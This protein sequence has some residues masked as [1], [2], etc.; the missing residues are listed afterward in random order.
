MPSLNELTGGPTRRQ[1]LLALGAALGGVVLSGAVDAD[2]VGAQIPP[3]QGSGTASVPNGYA[4][5]RV[6]TTESLVPWPGNPGKI[7]PIADLTGVVLM[8]GTTPRIF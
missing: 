3:G 7:N 4:F 2:A 5:Y 6:M 1:F 8:A